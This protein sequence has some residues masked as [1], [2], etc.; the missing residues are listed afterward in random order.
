MCVRVRVCVCACVRVCVCACVRVCVC[1]CARGLTTAALVGPVADAVDDA[2]AAI[3]GR[4]AEVRRRAP[5]LAR[6]TR[7]SLAVE[8]VGAVATVRHAVAELSRQRALARRRRRRRLTVALRK[9]AT[10]SRHDSRVFNGFSDVKSAKVW[11]V[12]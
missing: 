11:D 7:V 5:E 10:G 8:L 6:E 4:H 2:V 3:A 12:F 1:A 9:P